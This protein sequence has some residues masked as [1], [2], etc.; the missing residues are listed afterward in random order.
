M[1]IEYYGTVADIRELSGVGKSLQDFSNEDIEKHMA[2]GKDI[3]DAKT[4]KNNWASTDAAFDLVIQI[5]G[6][7]AAAFAL[8]RGGGNAKAEGEKYYN[9][10][11]QLLE[12]LVSSGIT[13]DVS[14]SDVHIAVTEYESYPLG[15]DDNPELEPYRSTRRMGWQ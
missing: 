14:D 1:P 13:G 7:F 2:A 8:M 6:N 15:L 3:V 9:M 11:M 4:G 10:A 12:I 5:E